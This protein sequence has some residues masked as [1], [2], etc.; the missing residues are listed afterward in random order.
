M[1]QEFEAAQEHSQMRTTGWY[2]MS[3]ANDSLASKGTVTSQTAEVVK[4]SY[5]CA[6]SKRCGWKKARR[7]RVAYR[8]RFSS[9][10]E[11]QLCPP[12]LTD[13]SCNI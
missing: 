13:H 9:R 8:G 2:L 7:V 1:M 3:L 5:P 10:G 11:I 6:L 12:A 4:R